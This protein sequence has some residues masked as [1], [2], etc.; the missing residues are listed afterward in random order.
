MHTH[1]HTRIGQ[2]VKT[3][4][5]ICAGTLPGTF[6]FSHPPYNPELTPCDFHLFTYLKQLLG[7][8]HVGSN[9]KVKQTVKD[10]FHGLVADFYD[11]GIQKL[12]ARYDKCPNLHWDYVEK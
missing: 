4:H 3:A 10:W 2:K 12:I 11:A 5:S 1:T 6:L 7:R 8:T 9:E